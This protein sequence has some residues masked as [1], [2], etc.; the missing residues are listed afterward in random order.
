MAQ[1]Q[2]MLLDFEELLVERQRFCRAHGA[3]RGQFT[4]GVGQDFSEMTGSGHREE[5]R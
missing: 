3:R 4:L 1:P 5:D 2:P